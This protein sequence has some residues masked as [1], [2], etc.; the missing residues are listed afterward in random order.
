MTKID[1]VKYKDHEI[2]TIDLG[3]IPRCQF[4]YGRL[5]NEVADNYLWLK[6]PFCRNT[7]FLEDENTNRWSFMR[8]TE[9]GLYQ[10]TWTYS[11]DS[12]VYEYEPVHTLRITA[13]V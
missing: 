9:D 12:L 5:H 11:A 4:F 3:S 1:I 8:V 2:N 6:L 13:E 7:D 10:D